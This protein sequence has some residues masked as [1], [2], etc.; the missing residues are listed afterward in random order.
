M[1][2]PGR[3][4]VVAVDGLPQDG[5]GRGRAPLGR[6]GGLTGPPVTRPKPDRVLM[7]AGLPMS[8]LHRR[9]DKTRLDTGLV[10]L[11]LLSPREIAP[12]TFDDG[13]VC[14]ARLA[15]TDPAL[16]GVGEDRG[17]EEPTPALA[18]TPPLRLC[19]GRPPIGRP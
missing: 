3:A 5:T 11:F 18:D 2:L 14:P 17:S 4:V 7:V 16:R 9:R 8:A 12:L 19:E 13:R 1:A 15:G 6:L 10:A